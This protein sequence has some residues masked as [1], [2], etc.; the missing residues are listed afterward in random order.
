MGGAYSLN[1]ENHGRPVYQ[2]D[3]PVKEAS[4]VMFYWDD[5]DGIDEQGWWIAPSIGSEKVWAFVPDLKAAT[6]QPPETG[7]KV[8]FDGKVDTNLKLAYR[9]GV[10]LLSRKD[11]EVPPAKAAE[12]KEQEKR[13][14]AL[15]NSKA[16][17]ATGRKHD[18]EQPLSKS[19]KVGDGKG[20]TRQKPAGVG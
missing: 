8:P 15:L 14:E 3:A 11:K 17:A 4:V 16:L 13:L 10:Q 9:R 7:W 12:P 19:H 18:L 20:E 1:G 2:Q 5:R 6:R